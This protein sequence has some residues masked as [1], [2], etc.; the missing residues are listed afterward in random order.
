M[1]KPRAK[2]IGAN[3]NI[4]NLM[5]VASKALKKSGQES[6][7]KEMISRVEKSESYDNALAIIMEY[8][9]VY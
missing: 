3:G 7:S 2:L 6:K 9:E 1:D 5:A 8:V 4:Y